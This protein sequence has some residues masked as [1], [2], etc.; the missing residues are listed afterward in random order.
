VRY[1]VQIVFTLQAY[2]KPTPSAPQILREFIVS[3]GDGR[4]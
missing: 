3:G 4:M 1:P 2:H